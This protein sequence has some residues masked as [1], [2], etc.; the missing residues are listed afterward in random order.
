VKLSPQQI[1]ARKAAEAT[2]LA[3]AKAAL[4]P[5]QN[6]GDFVKDFVP[7]D[8]LIDGLIQRR[9]VYSLTAP[10]GS[11]KTALSLLLAHQLQS[12]TDIGYR[13]VEKCRVLYLAGENPDDIRTRWVKQCEDHGI[14]PDKVDVVFVPDKWNIGAHWDHLESIVE[15]HGPF[16]VIIVDTSTAFFYGEDENDNVEAK[17]HADMFRRMTKLSGGPTV[18]V[19]CH[20]TKSPNMEALQ[21]RGGG[22]FTNEMDGNLVLLRE[23][24][25][26]E[27][28][29]HVK[30]RGPQFD[31]I[32]F[33]LVEGFSD[34]LRDAKGRKIGTITARAVSPTD[35]A[36][37]KDKANVKEEQLLALMKARPG[38]SM[39]EMAEQLRWLLKGTEP[40]VP[41]VQRTMGVLAGRKHVEKKGASWFTTK[42]GNNKA[43]TWGQG[44]LINSTI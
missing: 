33:K 43:G 17:A 2:A 3:A 28:W 42:A 37:T 12:G 16:G 25:I 27:L 36:E 31:P 10:T 19:N 30:F 11:G 1:A 9:Y 29:W 15:T 35:A 22:A 4:P 6:S 39:R 13:E 26:I 40:N 20:P 34:K 44:D 24:T 14:E 8:Y 7:P 32:P 38:L 5:A 41:Q 18:I 23:G 21:P